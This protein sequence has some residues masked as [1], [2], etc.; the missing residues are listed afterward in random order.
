MRWTWAVLV[1]PLAAGCGGSP[2][3]TAPVSPGD[4]PPAALSAAQLGYLQF[5]KVDETAAPDV[6]NLSGT[7]DFDD[8]RTA[9]VSAVVP[10]RV[11]ELLVHVGDRVVEGQPLL[12]IDSPEVKSAQAEYVRANS[13]LVVAHKAAERAARLRTVQ[14][15]AEKDFLQANEDAT[16]AAADFERARATLDRL[17]VE[18]GDRTTRYL[19]RTPVAGTVVERKAVLGQEVTPESADALVVVSDLARVKVSVRVPERQLGL[20]HAGEDVRVRVDAYPTEFPGRI[21]AVGAVVDDATRTVVARCIV[22]ND[23]ERLKPA[24]FARVTVTAP[25][26]VKLVA[27]PVA[28]VLSDGQ[29]SQVVVRQADGTLVLRTVELGAEVDGHVQILSGVS[30]GDEVVTQGALFAARALETS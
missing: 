25:P 22:P 6:A 2:A 13:D 24:M 17:H 27:V 16:K 30:L 23:E 14:A 11:T 20:V 4:T 7:I 15:I 5:G 29:R 10:G 19:L 28:A 21:A 9:R 26:D 8:E 12:A 18:P 1:A 3:E